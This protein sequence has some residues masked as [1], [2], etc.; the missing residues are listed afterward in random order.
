VLNRLPAFAFLLSAVVNRVDVLAGDLGHFDLSE[1]GHSVCS[2]SRDFVL[3]NFDAVGHALLVNTLARLAEV[4]RALGLLGKFE[5]RSTIG[6]LLDEPSHL[7]PRHRLGVG[8]QIEPLPDALA[9]HRDSELRPPVL[10]S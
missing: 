10:A 7:S 4:L 1:I 2:E 5:R 3:G 9:V 6:K 8:V